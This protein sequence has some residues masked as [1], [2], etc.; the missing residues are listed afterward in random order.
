MTKNIKSGIIKLVVKTKEKG[1]IKM[2][3]F[4]LGF[5]VAIVICG[6]TFGVFI[7]VNKEKFIVKEK[8]IVDNNNE[9]IDNKKENILSNEEI[10][11][12][13]SYVPLMDEFD[14]Y[15]YGYNKDAYSKEKTIITELDERLLMKEAFRLSEGVDGE[16]VYLNFSEK[17][18]VEADGYVL[19]EEFNK[20][21]KNLYNV[22]NVSTNKFV[23]CGGSVQVDKSGKYYVSLYGAGGW[24]MQKESK[25]IDYEI[26]N[27]MLIIYEKAGFVIVDDCGIGDLLIM[28]TTD[29]TNPF[30]RY[31]ED[32]SMSPD[33]ALNYVK[34]NFNEF[35]TFKHTFKSNGDGYYWYSTEI[36]NEEEEVKEVARKFIEAVNKK[37]WDNIELY[38][39]KEIA[40]YVK[41]YNISNMKIDLDEIEKDEDNVNKYFCY[42]SYDIDYKDYIKN[43]LGLGNLFIIEKVNDVFVVVTPFG[44]C[45]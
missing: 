30:K 42:S 35:N 20:T 18:P 24:K 3:K 31:T 22:D 23:I 34:E 16:P 12:Y 33:E 15:S 44:T 8:E 38:S 1:M 29:N 17:E 26:I 40:N 4:I 39:S 45:L 13:L 10:E 11:E 6:I 5:V 19:V 32:S 21:I 27:D 25:V 28:K 14:R 2:K 9:I 43:D 7:F 37:E 36:Q 41:E